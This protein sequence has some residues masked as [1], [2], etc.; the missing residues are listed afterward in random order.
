MLKKHLKNVMII[1]QKI[2]KIIFKKS[3]GVFSVNKLSNNVNKNPK[4]LPQIC[5]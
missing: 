1:F 5:L 2:L 4:N 3:L